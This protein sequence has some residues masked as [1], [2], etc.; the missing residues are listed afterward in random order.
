MNARPSPARVDTSLRHAPRFFGALLLLTCALLLWQWLGM[1]RVVELSAQSAHT[2]NASS[3]RG[4]G[5]SSSVALRRVGETLE[6]DCLIVRQTYSWPYCKLEFGLGGPETGVDFSDFDS[7]SVDLGYS[8]G[9]AGMTKLV[10]VNF[11]RG[12]STPG[13]WLTNKPNEVEPFDSGRP[14]V[15]PLDIFYV[16]SWWKTRVHPPLA[17]TGMRIDNVVGVDL[18]TAPDIAA[19]RHVFTLRSIRFHGKWITKNR[20]LTILIGLWIASAMGWV[21]LLSFTLRREL[22]TSK[23]QL[24]RLNEV[25]RA[26][27]LETEQ[28]AGQAH[29]DPLT[30]VLNREGLRA[31][32]MS[33]SNLMAEPVSIVFLDIDHFKCINDEHGHEV[34]DVVLRQFAATITANVRSADRLVRWGGEEF[35]LLCPMSDVSQAAALAEKLRLS[36]IGTRWPAATRITASFGVAQHDA[37]EEIGQVIKRADEQLYRAKRGG[38]NRVEADLGH[39]AQANHPAAVVASIGS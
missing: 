8:G 20:L 1:E 34:G 18:M 19:G 37:R 29:R 6:M 25:N 23:A 15:L 16:A 30:G 4:A 14:V 22:A 2:Q 12:W 9:G 31:E 21:G 7:V 10:L 24:G 35:L 5:G 27:R 17:R 3:D 33:T 32:L 36:L 39:V 26:L 11:E 13:Q 28:L 38:R